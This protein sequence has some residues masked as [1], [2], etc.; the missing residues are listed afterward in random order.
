MALPHL[1]VGI[2]QRRGAHL[3]FVVA[4]AAVIG[5]AVG[6]LFMMRATSVE[7]F[8][9]AQQW[10]HLPIFILVVALVAF[11]KLYFGTGRV[12][13]GVMGLAATS[14]LPTGDMAILYRTVAIQLKALHHQ[15][16]RH[17]AL[18]QMPA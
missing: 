16:T 17:Q 14:S 3:C 1:F 6:E 10:T 18:S 15:Q 12:W 2:W 11:V 13:L 4:A 7:Q 5:V 9:R 8:A